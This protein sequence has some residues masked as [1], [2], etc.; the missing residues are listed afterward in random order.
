MCD[1]DVSVSVLLMCI[2]V[3]MHKSHLQYMNLK[4]LS[5]KIHAVIPVCTNWTVKET[6]FWWSYLEKRKGLVDQLVRLGYNHAIYWTHIMVKWLNETKML[7]L[8]K[9]PDSKSV[10]KYPNLTLMLAKSC[11]ITR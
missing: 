10:K 2:A 9:H 6:R 4:Q 5:A 11:T 3:N 1:A 7:C 8:E